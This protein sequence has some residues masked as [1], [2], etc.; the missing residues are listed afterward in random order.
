MLFDEPTSALDPEMVG[1][2]LQVMRDLAQRRHD[3]DVRDARDGLCARSG[4][5]RLFMDAGKILETAE[6]EEFFLASETRARAAIPVRSCVRIEARGSPS[7]SVCPPSISNG[8]LY[9]Y[10]F[11]SITMQVKKV[12]CGDVGRRRCG[13]V[14][15]PGPC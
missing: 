5:P 15:C 3:D 2:V 4:R 10:Y 8:L 6:P 9:T 12:F 1:E 14:D 7:G 11:R 13:C